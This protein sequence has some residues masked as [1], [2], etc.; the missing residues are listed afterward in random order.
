MMVHKEVEVEGSGCPDHLWLHGEFEASLGCLRSCLEKS[1]PKKKENKEA[2]T[3][4]FL[5]RQTDRQ[6]DKHMHTLVSVYTHTQ[7]ERERERERERN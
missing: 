2:K 1:S 7:R 4:I 5:G 6:T 3:E